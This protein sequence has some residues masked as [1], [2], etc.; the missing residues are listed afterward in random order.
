MHGVSLNIGSTDPLDLDYLA[1]LKSLAQRIDPVFVSDHLCW[2]SVNGVNGHELLPLPLTQEALDHV[3]TRVCVVQEHLGRTLVLENPSSYV[4]FRCSEMTEWGFLRRLSEVTGCQLLL[5]VNNVYVSSVNLGFD[6]KMYIDSL[7]P[8]SVAYIHIAGHNMQGSQLI[9]THS[10][11][12]S[13]EVWQLY[14]Q[15][16][17]LVG[18]VPIMLEWD[19]DIPSFPELVAELDKAKSAQLV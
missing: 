3:I 14:Y 4:S 12:V 17:K 16:Q 13:N 5:D 11:S 8:D 10:R 1:Q 19:A 6:P 18:G 2:T 7:S 9:D 15:A